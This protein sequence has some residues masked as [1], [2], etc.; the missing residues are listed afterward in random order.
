MTSQQRK[1]KRG[2]ILTP[3][4]QQK[5][6]AA[7]A[8]IEQAENFGQKLTLEELSDRTGLDAGTV[9]KVLDGEK[10]CDRR[11][12]E[13]YFQALNL[14]LTEQNYSKAH[15][16]SQVKTANDKSFTQAVQISST[17]RTK[18]QD[19]EPN[20]HSDRQSLDEVT[21]QLRQ[22]CCEKIQHL[23]SKIQLLNRQQIDV[24]QLYVDVYLLEN[25][26]SESFATIP[27]LLKDKKARNY[28]DR[29]G[30]GRK[31]K[32]LSGLSV[33]LKSPRL[34]ILGKP[35]S[36]KSTFLRHLAV[37]CSQG[38][39]LED[40]IPILIELRSLQD[41]KEFDLVNLIHHEF[42]FDHKSHTE[43]ILDLGNVLILLDGLDEI[44]GEN[45]KRIQKNVDIFAQQYYQTRLIITCRTQTTEYV[46]D[47]FVCAEVAD[48]S[49]KQVKCFVQN[50]FN[51]LTESEEQ[52]K[53][54]ALSLMTHLK[55]PENRQ[56]AELAVTPILLSLTCWVFS[57]MNGLPPKISD[58]YEQGLSLLL[59]KWD[60]RRG[61]RRHLDH[62]I[63]QKLSTKER[64]N[65]LGFL[66]LNKFR[67]EQYILFK[68]REISEDISTYL[69]IAVEDSQIVLKTIEPTF[70]PLNCHIQNNDR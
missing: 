65:L 13:R 44:P 60:V 11:T 40:H 37:A 53:K 56:T 38:K 9:A 35:G 36:G 48:F 70:R 46:L 33:A 30:L 64:E 69:D 45:R 42:G 58:L 43:H 32:R 63:Y 55:L 8:E 28:F 41:A 49:P 12:L 27:S 4:G 52:G 47:K 54:Q 50:W 22:R 62:C 57:H 61:I 26:S 24:D 67:K 10:G 17:S 18:Q 68:E 16:N 2:V 5:L 34:M 3:Q 66:A 31:Q 51:T 19:W 21:Q 23:Y 59:E 25:L 29:L 39:F 14:E 15:L 20:S 6:R 7:I 1:R